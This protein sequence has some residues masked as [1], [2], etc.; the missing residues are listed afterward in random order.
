MKLVRVGEIPGRT[1]SNKNRNN[2][3]EVLDNFL[4]SDMKFAR[5]VWE[6]YGYANIDSARA[7][8]YQTRKQQH[9]RIDIFSRNGELYLAK[10]GA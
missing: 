6:P 8:L 9:Y 7:A 4:A 2:V 10:K 1:S 3:V 5:V